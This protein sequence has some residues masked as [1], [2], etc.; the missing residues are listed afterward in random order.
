MKI[1]LN[2]G[3]AAVS[4]RADDADAAGVARLK[5]LYESVGMERFP[6]D[7]KATCRI[8]PVADF[9]HGRGVGIPHH[10]MR[11][12]FSEA[13]ERGAEVAFSDTATAPEK[14]ELTRWRGVRKLLFLGLVP[15]MMSMDC[16]MVHGALLERDGRGMLLC[17]P[18]GIGKSTTAGRMKA[19]GFKVLADDCFLLRRSAEGKYFARPLPTWSIYLFGKEA[20]AEC[21]ARREL[22]ISRIFILGR[23]AER[24]TPLDAQTALLGCAKAFTDMVQWHIMRYPEPLGGAL[25][26]RALAAAERL[27]RELPCGALQL[28]LDCNI[29]RLLPDLDR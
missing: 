29:S 18:S 10:A 25:L 11:V 27:V 26:D 5:M 16:S 28:T 14:L 12:D 22:S 23:N 6:D 13:A 4:W 20:L 3:D 17:G 8:I 24:Y 19:E 2:F 1:G 21:D 9:A 15:R 7:G